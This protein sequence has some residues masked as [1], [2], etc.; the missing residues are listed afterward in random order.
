MPSPFSPRRLALAT[1]LV[2]A[3]ALAFTSGGRSLVASVLDRIATAASGPGDRYRV[4]VVLGHETGRPFEW[5]ATVSRT[6]ADE[7]E[8]APRKVR[9]RYVEQARR[10]LAERLGYNR[11]AFGDDASRLVSSS[12]VKVEITDKRSSRVIDLTGPGV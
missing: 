12:V 8:F 5:E 4:K 6:D 3:A 11:P 9:D 7:A 1:V 2:L 10:A